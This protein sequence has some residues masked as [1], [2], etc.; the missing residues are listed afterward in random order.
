M[1]SGFSSIS[2]SASWV[3]ARPI[4]SPLARAPASLPTF[5][6]VWTHTPTSSRSGRR[7]IARIAIE[8]IPPVDQTAT[9]SGAVRMRS[10]SVSNARALALELCHDTR[11]E[12]LGQ[13][14]RASGFATGSPVAAEERTGVGRQR[15]QGGDP[16]RGGRALRVVGAPRLAEADRRR[17]RDPARE[18]LPP[19]RLEGG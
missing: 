2:A 15:T 19:L 10:S 18:P 1:Q 13:R 7:W 6:G 16:R 14:F 5:S 12:Y 17:V 3:V 9:R 11:N 4:G 8:P